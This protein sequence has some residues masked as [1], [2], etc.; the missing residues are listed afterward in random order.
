LKDAGL[1]LNNILNQPL[2]IEQGQKEITLLQAAQEYK[3]QEAHHSDLAKIIHNFAKYPEST[4]I[5]IQ[6]L[7][8]LVEDIR[9][10]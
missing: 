9:M 5:L 8:L 1:I 3:H 2:E 7:E 10:R 4:K 6:E